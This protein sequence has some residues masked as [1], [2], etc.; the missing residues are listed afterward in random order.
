MQ[1]K[2]LQKGRL[3]H[4]QA[5]AF[6]LRVSGKTTIV[7]HEGG[8]LSVAYDW[9]N[10]NMKEPKKKTNKGRKTEREETEHHSRQQIYM[11]RQVPLQSCSVP[12]DKRWT[13]GIAAFFLVW[14][15]IMP[16]TID[17]HG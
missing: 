6:D 16:I 8:C 7:L 17:F 4:A 15:L 5:Q 3:R 9:H 13:L 10:K 1:A 2:N 11:C 12:P 14:M